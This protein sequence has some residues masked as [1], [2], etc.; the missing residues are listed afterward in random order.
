MTRRPTYEEL[1]GRIAELECRLDEKG[2]EDRV[3]SADHSTRVAA[4][5]SSPDN[6]V[7]S[8]LQ[9]GM[10]LDVSDTFLLTSGYAR[11]EVV[12]RSVIDIGIWSDSEE[13]KAFITPLRE[14]GE[15]RCFL[16]HFTMKDGRT[17]PFEISG[18]QVEIAGEACVVSISRDVS[19]IKGQEA[20]LRKQLGTLDSIFRAAPTGI[21]MV[22]DRVIVAANQRLCDMLGYSP[23]EL[24]NQEARM[25]YPT[26]AESDWVG[27]EKYEQIARQGTGT[28]ET[29]WVR[30][31][32]RI[33]DVLLSSTPIDLTDLSAGVTFTALDITRRKAAEQ[34]LERQ[35]AYLTTLHETA[36]GLV[37]HLE[38]NEVLTAIVQNA[39]ALINGSDGFVYI[40]DADT[41]E[42]VI[43]AATGRYAETL[44]G[45]RMKAGD[46]LAGKVLQSGKPMWV[47]DYH[48]WSGRSSH[49]VFDELHGA[50]SVPIVSRNAVV[51]VIGM[52]RFSE[53]QPFAPE[54]V[55]ILSRFADLAAIALKNAELYTDLQRELGE[56][57]SVER[58]LQ[59]KEHLQEDVFES[60]Q[61]GVSVLDRDLNVVYV[62]A[63]MERF[64]GDQRKIVGRKCYACYH[65]RSEPCPICPTRRCFESGKMESEIVPGLPGSPAEWVE[66]FSFPI[67]DRETGAIRGAAEFVRDITR[68]KA[69]EQAL[70]RQKSYLATLHETAL[71]LVGHLEL[72][73]VLTAIVQNAAALISGADG[74][75]Y[76]HDPD[77]DE[78]VIKAATGSYAEK[79]RG[80]RLK[81]GEGLAGRVAQS[82]RPLV[83]EDYQNWPG[84]SKNQL[85]K[86]LRAVL[87]APIMSRGQLLGAINMNCFSGD[88]Q[89]QPEDVEILSRFADLAAIALENA[90]LYSQVQTELHE[91][92]RME[93]MLRVREQ[94]YRS[95]FENT[96]TG[97]VLSEQDTTLSMVNQGFADL[98]GYSR[99]EI[100]GRMKWTELVDPAD[101]ARMLEIHY[102]RRKDPAAAPKAFECGL[103]DRH[104][105]RK[106]VL[107][108]VDLIPGTTTSVG[109]FADISRIKK[110]EQTLR[111]YQQMVTSSSDYMALMDRD[112]T[113]QVVNAPYA[114]AMGRA[115]EEIVGQPAAGIFGR[116]L[117]E[118]Y[119]KP[120]VDQCL[121]GEEIHFKAWYDTPGLG[122]R[123]IDTFYYP[124]REEDG[125][126]SGVVIVG[127]D[128]TDLRKLEGQLLQAQ[129]MEAV[130]TLAGGVAHDF[131]NLLMGIQGR[132]SLMLSE[133]DTRHPFHEHLEGIESYVRNAV[134]LTRQILGF[135]RGGKYEV[136]PTDLNDLIQTQNRMFGRTRKE[137]TIRGKYEPNLWAVEVDRGQIKQVLLNLYV[138][139]WQ[140]MPGGGDLL[141]STE[142]VFLTEKDTEQFGLSPGRFVRV[143][144]TD[145]GVGMDRG[146]MDRIF[147]PFFTTREMGRGTGLGLASAYGI[148][149]NHGGLIHVYSEKGEGST[150]SIYLPASSRP[151]EAQAASVR[152]IAKGQGRLLLVDD[153][154][155]ILEVGAA[156]LKK[157]GYSVQTAGSGEE[158]LQFYQEHGDTI[159][160]VIL[161]MVMPGMGGGEVFD[162]LKAVDPAIKV[163]LSSGYSING[164]A[165]EIIDR[166]CDGFIQKPFN[167]AQ[168]SEKVA[169]VLSI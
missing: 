36:L 122:R 139:A 74:I 27:K 25:L 106:D 137:I 19:E 128:I 148:I 15:V 163:L 23:D 75:A 12:G 79:L 136:K 52:T 119:Q 69:A 71:G 82:G 135:A 117:F 56:R 143:V 58:K 151:V 111:K 76:I 102:L 95:V 90:Y 72:D 99:D 158:A 46:G 9:D 153:E 164:K 94:H 160:L 47:D 87:S 61:D 4:F 49:P 155:M 2:A 134:D 115:F 142:N 26:Q 59:E 77:T 169:E 60:I 154:E 21:G 29:R 85:F 92:K 70:E 130:G 125:T 120:K 39:A 50:L 83:V 105:V 51:G 55:D 6:M 88:K 152:T 126:I 107:L 65:D 54:E 33:I 17:R 113:F 62:N 8:R 63:T 167:L 110:A 32:G 91:K 28:V 66:V 149:K 84:R 131:N 165:S 81:M 10:I 168:L 30:K 43:K 109:S 1:E 31:D 57:R 124:S 22:R 41:H 123:Y 93:E 101:H 44:L 89:F 78:M 147:E 97:T 35:K 53:G 38:L 24:M 133:V 45:F 162:R 86:D 20:E 18:R 156:M 127:R 103:I 42:M 132:T 141:L 121:A 14:C 159:D 3:S 161:D 80:F 16:A 100:E 96:G 73:E 118:R 108:S 129:K 34:A 116:E 37:R 166:G 68:R 112:Y 48:R 11:E 144:V 40:F 98:V 145:N 114:A 64:Y 146:T 5:M 104:G 140:A 150:F 138:N 157:L 67:R 13:R 7:I